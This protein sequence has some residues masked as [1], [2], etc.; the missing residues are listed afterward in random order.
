[1]RKFI[2]VKELAELLSV[3][4]STIWRWTSAKILPQPIKITA[5]TTVWDSDEILKFIAKKEAKKNK[6]RRQNEIR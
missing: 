1:M 2:K 5:R 6:S 3:S 4:R